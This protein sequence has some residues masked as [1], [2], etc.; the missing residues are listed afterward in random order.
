MSNAVIH[1]GAQPTQSQVVSVELKA[2][3]IELLKLQPSE[4]RWHGIPDL[5]QPNYALYIARL[6]TYME[7]A[8]SE[9]SQVAIKNGFNLIT[10]DNPTLRLKIRVPPV[11]IQFTQTVPPETLDE[12][13]N[14]GWKDTVLRGKPAMYHSSPTPE[15]VVEVRNHHASMTAPTIDGSTNIVGLRYLYVII[16]LITVFL[17]THQYPAFIDADH[18]AEVSG[19]MKLFIPESAVNPKDNPTGADISMTETEAGM[20]L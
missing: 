7:A 17:R 18:E 19:Y 4:V 2:Q 13:R 10:L 11:N 16:D 20:A 12:L 15:L 5:I 14:K 9:R 6:S 3:N 8:A 1:F